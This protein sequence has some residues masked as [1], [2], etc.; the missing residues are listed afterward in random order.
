MRLS[1]IQLQNYRS[2]RSSGMIKFG[3]LNIL[4][5]RNN[6]G[7]SVI[8]R[9]VGQLQS[10]VVDP[11]VADVRKGQ[12]SASI[13]CM[14]ED[15]NSS[16]F[17]GQDIPRFV[18][19]QV[20]RTISRTHQGQ[21]SKT[22]EI[23]SQDT[24]ARMH[25]LNDGISSKEPNNFIYPYFSKRKVGE[26]DRM[27]DLNK[28]RT[29]VDNLRFL[30]ARVADL[31]NQDNPSSSEYQELC[32]TVLGFR[33]SAHPADDGNGQQCGVYVNSYEHIPIEDMGEGV[34]NLVG[35]ITMLCSAQNKLFIIEE[36]EN[37]VHPIALKALLD[38]IVKKSSTNQ[39]I[40]STHSNIVVKY[41]ASIEGSKLYRVDMDSSS[42]IPT[43]SVEPVPPIPQ[44]RIKLLEELGYELNDFDIWDGWLFLE[45]ASAE[46]IIRDYLIPLFAPKLNRIR[47]LSTNGTGNIH[48]RFNDFNRLFLFTHLEPQYINKAWVIADG[49]SSEDTSGSE[50]IEKLKNIYVNPQGARWRDEQFSTWSEHD[51]EKYYPL[52]FSAEVTRVLSITDR[53]VL[54]VQKEQL[55]EAV[56][57]WCDAQNKESLRNTFRTSAS[58]VI[59]KLQEIENRLF[60]RVR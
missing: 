48:K 38:T 25:G 54:R 22:L 19:A 16:H 59:N 55:L 50:A 34:P 37:D 31:S 11:T 7:K 43:S 28:T 14:L 47:T 21:L 49:D 29:V 53:Q 17:S 44:A 13:K 20:I 2:F 26:Y 42:G 40:I 41:I 10:G 57:D 18:N 9:G 8:L 52:H 1:G 60:M 35:L 27:I 51:F 33:I 46:R 45:E 3:N 12:P 4:V 5:G 24:T 58:E 15:V 56:R 32:Q 23:S 39:F 30:T 36:L 6:S